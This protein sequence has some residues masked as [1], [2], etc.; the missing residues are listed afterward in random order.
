M[1][2]HSEAIEQTWM[3]EFGLCVEHWLARR[4]TFITK[5]LLFTKGVPICL[6]DSSADNRNI[7][8]M[9]FKLYFKIM[10]AIYN[11]FCNSKI[12]NAKEKKLYHEHTTQPQKYLHV[13]TGPKGVQIYKKSKVEY[14]LKTYDGVSR[15]VFLSDRPNSSNCH[16][17]CQKWP[18]KA[19]K[20]TSRSSKT[21]LA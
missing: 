16:L 20:E 19:S 3:Q 12:T 4:L 2:K 10:L 14:C 18:Y 17:R 5:L 6:T 8:T 7:Y 13:I 11:I 21:D 1:K 15:K 9:F